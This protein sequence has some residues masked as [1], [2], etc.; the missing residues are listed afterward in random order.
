MASR[1]DF[2]RSLVAIP[3]SATAMRLANVPTGAKV[4]KLARQRVGGNLY[5][6]AQASGRIDIGDILAWQ[7]DGTVARADDMLSGWVAGVSVESLTSG[8]Y[9]W[10]QTAGVTTVRVSS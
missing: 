7:P 10:L 3:L 5:V 8:A 4:C 1:R 2:L 6:Y 9:G